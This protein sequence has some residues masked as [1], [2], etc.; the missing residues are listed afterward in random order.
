M[1]KVVGYIR[2]STQKQFDKGHSRSEQKAK[3]EQYAR[4]YDLEIVAI[5]EDAKSGKTMKGRDGLNKAL[6]M[7][8]K[9]EASGVL[10]SKLDR[11]CRSLADLNVMVEKYFQENALLSVSENLNTQ[12]SC[13]RLILNVIMSVA[14]WE[15]E[16]IVERIQDTMDHLKENNKRAGTI[17]FGFMVDG[18]NNLIKNKAEQSILRKIRKLKKKGLSFARIARELNELELF[19]RKGC[20]WSKQGIHNLWKS[21]C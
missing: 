17:P 7:L 9:G 12:D 21:A 4:L 10:V 3:I 19:N 14:Q 1:K 18:E 16:K 2:T 6:E 5:F 15:R 20:F 11:L 8:D 13:G